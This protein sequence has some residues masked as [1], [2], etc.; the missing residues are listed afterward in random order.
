L[1]LLGPKGMPEDV[2]VQIRDDLRKIATNKAIVD[3]VGKVRM[4]TVLNTPAEFRQLWSAEV[5]V[6]RDLATKLKPN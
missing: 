4:Y 2:V 6:W 3:P 5:E 1:G